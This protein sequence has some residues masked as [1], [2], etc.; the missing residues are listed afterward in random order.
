MAADPQTPITATLPWGA[1][2]VLKAAFFQEMAL[3]NSAA[4]LAGYDGP[5]KVIVG[6]RDDVV[7][8]QPAT[9][10]ALLRYHDGPE[11]LSVFDTDHVWDAFSG[12][13]V[14]DEQMVPTTLDWLKTH[15]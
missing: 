12:P 11:A 3:T 9:S 1:E 5:L 8:P 13:Q 6:S 10:E 7:A 2:T 15:M 14:L 4:A